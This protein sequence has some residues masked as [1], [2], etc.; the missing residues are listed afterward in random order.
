MA[1]EIL[2]IENEGFIA[3]LLSKS[4]RRK[5][6]DIFVL[7]HREALKR[8][9]GYKA[10]LVLL[11]APASG[12]EASETCRFLRD[13]TAA[14]IIALTE[15]PVELEDLDGVEYLTKPLVF[16]ELL[17][18]VENAL[19]RRRRPRKRKVR[20]L[21]CGDLALDLRT[22]ALTKGEHLY[23]LTPKEFLLLKLFM[24][25]PGK[26]L[27]HKALMKR[28]WNTDY[29]DDRRTLYVHVS[30]I[31]KKIEDAP[32]KPVYLRTVRGVG[33]RFEAKP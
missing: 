28:V 18:A 32:E 25:S 3:D 20:V 6:Y 7:G 17:K 27:S 26:V 23:R 1:K 31:R 29:L 2:I 22:R 24:R 4:L 10:S 9:R 5:G 13:A 8:A 30:W 19:K 21:R 14:P 11:E 16:R 12:A 15:S 33:Y